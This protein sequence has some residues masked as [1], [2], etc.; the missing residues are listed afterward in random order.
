[1]L[2]SFTV[3]C[4]SIPDQLLVKNLHPLVNVIINHNKF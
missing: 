3:S 1:M 2:L 4:G